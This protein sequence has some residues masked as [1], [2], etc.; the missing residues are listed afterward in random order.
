MPTKELSTV[1]VEQVTRRREKLGLSKSAFARECGMHP[2]SISQIELG[3]MVPYPA[4][5]EKMIST[6][7]RLESEAE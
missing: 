6:L 7:D 3:R 5:L 2:S 4:Q 1:Q